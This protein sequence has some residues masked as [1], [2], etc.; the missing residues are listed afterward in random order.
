[1]LQFDMCRCQVEDE[2][3]EVEVVHEV[4]A[5]DHLFLISGPLWRPWGPQLLSLHRPVQL[6]GSRRVE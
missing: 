2:D 6:G 5:M 4:L 3:E 1:M